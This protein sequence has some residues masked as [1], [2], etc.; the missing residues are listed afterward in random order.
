M[1]VPLNKY[2]KI[3]YRRYIEAE[4]MIPDFL[5]LERESEFNRDAFLF[6]YLAGHGCADDR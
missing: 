3:I 4:K 1:Q 2:E 6:I 5:Q